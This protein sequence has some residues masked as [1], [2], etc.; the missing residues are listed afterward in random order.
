MMI[1][2]REAL[3]VL[4]A[5]L[6]AVSGGLPPRDVGATTAISSG[7]R[8]RQTPAG[9][10]RGFS[11]TVGRLR[12]ELAPGAAVGGYGMEDH[13]MHLHGHTFQ[14]VAIGDRPVAGPFKD[15]LTL[16]HMDSYDVEF[17]AANP[18][19]WLFH[20]HNLRHMAGGMMTE[21]RYA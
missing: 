19:R 10:V 15:T 21:L 2:R 3:P 20:C 4:A 12:W 5:V 13:P 9:E 7:A 1:R 16:R 18:G 8:A 6:L 11:L 17:V 14:L